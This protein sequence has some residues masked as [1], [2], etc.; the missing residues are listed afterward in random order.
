VNRPRAADDFP[1]IR[2]RMKEL[3]LERARPVPLTTL[4]PSERAWKSCAA[5]ALKY[6]LKR[7][8]VR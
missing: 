7:G 2:A 5:S 3:R 1:R 6:L 8:A 4:R